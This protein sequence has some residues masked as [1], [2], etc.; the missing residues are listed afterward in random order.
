MLFDVLKVLIVDDDY[1]ART[2]IKSLVNWNKEGFEICGEAANGKTAIEIIKKE[3]PDIV[4]TDMSMPVFDGASLIK[5]LEHN[6]P[7]IRAIA[8]SGYDDF[9]YVRKSMKHGAVDYILKHRLDSPTLMEVLNVA[10]SAIL[11]ERNNKTN[12]DKLKKQLVESREVLRQHFIKQLVLGAINN[13]KEIVEKSKDLNMKLDAQNLVLAVSEI[14]D[15]YL[16]QEKFSAKEVN[17]LVSSMLNICTEILR[18]KEFDGAYVG[19][20]EDGRFVFVFSFGNRRSESYMYQQS[21]TTIERIRVSI[22]RYLN[23]TASFCVSRVFYNILE[24]SQIYKDTLA[25]LQSKF[26]IGK[27]KI[28]Q[29]SLQAQFNDEYITL[30]INDEKNIVT[31]LKTI[32]SEEVKQHINRIFD[33]VIKRRGSYKSV[34]MICIELINIINRVAMEVGIDVKTVYSDSEIP[35]E[36]MKKYETIEEVKEWILSIYKRMIS[37]IQIFNINSEYTEPTKKAMLFIHKNYANNISLSDAAEYLGLNPSYLSRVFK[38]DCGL[39]FVEYLNRVR[40]EHAKWLIEKGGIKLKDVVSE[41]G[42]NNYTY[43]FKVFRRINKMTPLEYEEKCRV[44]YI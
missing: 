24:I 40:I 31:A 25:A 26:F 1:M 16:L 32:N 4:I 38:E 17:K 30:D 42:F 6:Y 3:A 20:M 35:Y 41:V 39:G 29:E 9:D 33:K 8:I 10:R 13:Q 12:N 11:E 14:D 21:I 27:D 22:N 15:F 19:H 18:E 37:L 28:I 44:K 2:H 34:Q 7:D 43:F 5:Y 23:I 36:K